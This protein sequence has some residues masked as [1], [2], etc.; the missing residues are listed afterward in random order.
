MSLAD[1][2]RCFSKIGMES[3]AVKLPIEYV[4]K[5]PLP[6]I[7]Y[8]QQRHFVV[9]YK[10]NA[11]KQKYYIADP[12]QG[13]MVYTE[14]DFVKYWIPEGSQEGLTV[15]ADP[16]EDFSSR[17][18]KKE[19]NLRNFFS[20]IFSY[21]RGH[22]KSFLVSFLI[23]LVI[24][25]TD[26]VTPLLLQR[27]IDE[28]IGLKDV[29][30]V[31]NLLLCQLAIF[32]GGLVSGGVLNLILSK[33]GL[34]INLEMVNNFLH[35][36][37]RFPLSFFDRKVSA[38]FVQKIDDQSRI[39]DFLLSCPNSFFL[40]VLNL[41]VFSTLL[42]YYSPLIFFLFILIS[43]LEIGW[44]AL[45]L[46]R[47]K[48]LNYAYFT[49]S[50]A[51]RNYAFELTG[52]MADLKVNNAVKSRI[53]R[54][55]KTQ[56]TLNDISMKSAWLSLSQNSGHSVISRIKEL[57]VTGISAAM[58]IHGD[59]T[60]GIMM[61]LG[62]I[63]GRLAQ[64]FDTISSTMSQL[65]DAYLSYQ[66]IDDVIHDDSD[67]RGHKTF[68]DATIRFENVWFKYAGF[69]S[70]FVIRDLSLSVEQGKVTALVGESGSGKST[71]L[72]L[73]MGF[74]V[75]PKGRLYLSGSPV[76]DIDNE[77]WLRHC[78]VVMQETKI[79]TGSILENITLSDE[80]PDKEKA[81]EMLKLVG[82]HDFVETLPMK[83]FTRIGVSGIQMSGGQKQR[84]MIARALYKNPD[85]LFLDEATSSLD[86][87]N[88]RIIVENLR[89][90]GRGRTLVVAAHRL[91]TVQHA[92]KIV[93]IKDGRI[94]EM[95][96]HEELIALGGEYM[97]LVKNQLALSS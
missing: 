11:K 54:W 4:K 30:L 32:I 12:A 49:N 52:G 3:L 43:F 91:S 48:T 84:L 5:M 50:S 16:L 72:K 37:A 7:L 68:H 42:C 92:D 29:G 60:F 79:F 53:A 62:Y 6:A 65:Q 51:N 85:I 93:F 28:G 80:V 1:I 21:L 88:E 38:D 76:E 24:M 20:Y 63:T 31:A 56:S 17:T 55:E 96:T 22:K 41:L 40:V 47:R 97:N 2:N 57:L 64:P 33:T 23:T 90:F 15:L 69:G 77:D 59:M 45:F 8:W 95:G 73:M 83:I 46:N 14:A 36:L 58:V 34:D 89:Q 61:T 74:Y 39:K 44:N 25:A 66:R 75:P 70:P 13:K 87:N 71:L 86:A 9:L 10:V 67:Q 27:T 82:L 26:F 94:A 35:R 78:G 19:N 18:Y 81:L